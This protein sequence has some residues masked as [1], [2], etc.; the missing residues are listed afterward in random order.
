[1]EIKLESFLHWIHPPGDY[2]KPQSHRFYEI[3]YYEKGSGKT[4][5]DGEVYSYK[6]DCIAVITPDTIH[7]EES[8][9]PTTV[10][11]CLFSTD[12][13]LEKLQITNG[14]NNSAN[15][16]DV[17]NLMYK[18]KEEMQSKRQNYEQYLNLLM[19]QVLIL[20]QR[21]QCGDHNGSASDGIEYV[22]IFLKENYSNFI[23]FDL[24]AEQIGYSYDRFRHLFKESTGLSP[25]Q[26]L[27]NIRIAKAKEYLENSSYSI[28][29]I[30][31]FCGFN[32]AS[33]FIEMFKAKTGFTPLKYRKLM[34]VTGTDV[35]NFEDLEKE[36]VKHFKQK[37]LDL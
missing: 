26:Y 1:M 23:D 29:T 36:E 3:I 31:R 27:I 28:R 34:H 10:L 12:Q 17:L 16:R 24:L 4:T 15:V 30:S 7:D 18:I 6:E 8:F 9:E 21:I 19:G 35:L 13:P 33:K 2:V 32:N 20:L 5:I 37:P 11:F 22:K 25:T 14:L